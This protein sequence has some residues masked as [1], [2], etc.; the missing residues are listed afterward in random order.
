MDS[1][2]KFTPQNVKANKA[3]ILNFLQQLYYYPEKNKELLRYLDSSNQGLEYVYPVIEEINKMV[4]N[5]HRVFVPSGHPQDETLKWLAGQRG[6]KDD[7]YHFIATGEDKYNTVELLHDEIKQKNW[8]D[9][10]LLALSDARIVGVKDSKG[11]QDYMFA[12]YDSCITDGAR[13]V[14]NFSPIR[15]DNKLVGY[16]YTDTVTNQYPYD[17]FPANEEVANLVKFVGLPI[18]AVLANDKEIEELKNIEKTGGD[19]SRCTDKLY[20][21]DKLYSTAYINAN[22]LDLKG[23]Y[24]DRSGKLYFRTNGEGRIIF[25]KCDCEGSGRPSVLSMWGSCFAVFNVIN[26]EMRLDDKRDE[27]FA[28]I[29]KSPDPAHMHSMNVSWITERADKLKKEGYLKEAEDCYNHAI[30][31]NE[32]VRYRKD[33]VENYRPYLGLGKLHMEQG[34][35]DYAEVCFNK[36]LNCYSKELVNYPYQKYKSSFDSIRLHDEYLRKLEK[37]EEDMREYKEDYDAFDRLFIK[38]PKKPAEVKLD[39]FLYRYK[40]L[41]LMDIF[42]E[43]KVICQIKG[44]KYPA[45]ICHRASEELLKCTPKA[46]DI[47][48]RRSEGIDYIGDLFEGE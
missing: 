45:F 7:L 24:R 15:K 8:Y 19:V 6:V 14:Y 36:A 32:L 4:K 3:N 46:Y 11:A 41:E 33:L 42:D 38:P 10:N 18:N 40:M 39:D 1:D 22:K 30:S 17:E 9:F 34:C 31:F 47:M 48:V 20:P 12:A 44:E 35:Y 21:L 26:N 5:G 23:D 13:G 2:I 28:E 16:S 43:L 37:Y 29:D 27:Y 25:P